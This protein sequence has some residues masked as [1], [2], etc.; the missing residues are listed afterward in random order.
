MFFQCQ[1]IKE[2]TNV[3]WNMFSI[4]IYSDNACGGGG[5]S[6]ICLW[7]IILIGFNI[8][9]HLKRHGLKCGVDCENPLKVIKYIVKKFP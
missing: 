5:G 6:D 4:W 9:Q 2:K 8:F 7:E 3:L 1:S